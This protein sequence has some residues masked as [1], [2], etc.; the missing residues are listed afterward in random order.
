[1]IQLNASMKLQIN[2]CVNGNKFHL[3]VDSRFLR[4]RNWTEM[5]I[6][7]VLEFAF[8]YPADRPAVHGLDTCSL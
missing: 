2:Y 5:F 1:M 7:S 3:R 6:D 4:E 8:E